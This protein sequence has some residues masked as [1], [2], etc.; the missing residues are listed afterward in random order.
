MTIGGNKSVPP[1][2]MVETKA[3]KWKNVSILKRVGA[4]VL[5]APIMGHAVMFTLFGVYSFGIF[6]PVTI[7]FEGR[8]RQ[9]SYWPLIMQNSCY[10]LYSMAW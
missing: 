5:V 8:R 3:Q 7:T 6:S 4:A 2:L 1:I 9:A 10:R